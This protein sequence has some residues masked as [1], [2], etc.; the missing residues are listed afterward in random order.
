MYYVRVHALINRAMYYFIEALC[1]LTGWI[2]TAA[3]MD[4]FQVQH[5][6]GV[7][8]VL[9]P[10]RPVHLSIAGFD[11]CYVFWDGLGMS[12]TR[13]RYNQYGAQ[14]LKLFLHACH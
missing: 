5:P 3:A 12:V 8:D 9:T 7:T 4:L 10:F 14:H 13:P 2:P 1:M 6:L 11:Q